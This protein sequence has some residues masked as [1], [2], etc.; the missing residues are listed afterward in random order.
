MFL[1]DVATRVVR[2]RLAFV[3]DSAPIGASGQLAWVESSGR[4]PVDLIVQRGTDL[5]VFVVEDSTA[6]F[7]ALPNAQAGR[8]VDVNLPHDTLVVSRGQGRLQDG[9]ALQVSLE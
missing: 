2:A 3:D 9:D 8:P 6:R 5:G 1:A 7:V 4:L